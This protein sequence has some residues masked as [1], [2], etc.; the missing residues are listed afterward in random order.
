VVKL[1]TP[2]CLR[3]PSIVCAD[4]IIILETVSTDHLIVLE[5]DS[6]YPSSWKD[7][8]EIDPDVLEWIVA[9]GDIESQGQ[10]V[11]YE[12]TQKFQESWGAKLPWAE[13][14]KGGDGLFDYVRCLICSTFEIWE[15][16]LRPKWDTLKKHGGTSRKRGHK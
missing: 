12:A 10:K 9:Q 16:I 14:V 13:C 3:V 1:I 11:S 2:D 5:S 15:K 6:G 7:E 4:D 8:E